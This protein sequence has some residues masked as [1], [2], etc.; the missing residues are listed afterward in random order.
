MGIKKFSDFP[1]KSRLHIVV[2][3]LRNWLLKIL[4]KEEVVECKR[5]EALAKAKEEAEK[6]LLEERDR[7]MALMTQLQEVINEKWNSKL[8]TDNL[9]FTKKIF[10]YFNIYGNLWWVV[11]NS[12]CPWK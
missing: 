12:F 11:N 7:N 5:L 10:F 6:L 3:F 4:K 1:F 2:D 9:K 8:S